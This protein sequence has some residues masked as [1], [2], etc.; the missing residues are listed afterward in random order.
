MCRGIRRFVGLF[1]FAY[2]FGVFGLKA[3]VAVRTTQWVGDSICVAF[4]FKLSKHEKISD[5]PSGLDILWHNAEVINKKA[6]A[7]NQSVAYR[8]RKISSDKPLTYDVF[9]VICGDTCEPRSATGE[10]IQNGLLSESEAAKIF[11]I[12]EDYATLMYLVLMAFLGG[13]ILNLMPCVFPIITL[14]IFSIAKLSGKSLHDVR[15]ETCLFASGIFFVF[16]TLGIILLYLKETTPVIGWGFFMQEPACVFSLML[17]FLACALHFLEICHFRMPNISQNSRRTAGAFLSGIL[18]G[19]ASS[20]CVGPFAGVAIAGAVL[21]AEGMQSYALLFAL[22]CGV[23]LPYILI[24]LFPNLMRL[25]PKP[26]AWLQIFQNF[27]G[28]AMLASTVWIFSILLSQLGSDG[29][30]KILL[31]VLAIVFLLNQLVNIKKNQVWRYVVVVG[32]ITLTA[33]GYMQTMHTSSEQI[34]WNMYEPSTFETIKKKNKK[35]FLNF[36]ADWCLNCKYNATVFDD[37]QV[38]ETFKK[39]EIV[40]IKCDWTKGDKKITSLLRQYNSISVPLYILIMDG[41]SKILSNILTRK[42]LIKAIEGKD[43]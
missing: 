39:N 27:M 1:L 2:C 6:L 13:L 11:G 16:F 40:A 12:H 37:D 21:G 8:I 38:I 29:A 22:S 9:Y 42:N 31:I 32:V 10:I 23:A 3:E 17:V 43:E 19:V 24:A 20:S 41:K 33:V 18:S 5:E 26:G 7:D 36:T 14:K 34:H 15:K 4:D 30:I 28:Y 25:M 35:I